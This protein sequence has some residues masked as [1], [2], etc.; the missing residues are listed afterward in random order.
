MFVSVYESSVFVCFY[1][2]VCGSVS[3]HVHICSS[4]KVCASKCAC[5]HACLRVYGWVYSKY[6]ISQ[7]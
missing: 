5:V 7:S 6:L 4:T 3:D 2:L 1:L